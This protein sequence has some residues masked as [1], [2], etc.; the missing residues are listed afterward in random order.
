V[1][2]TAKKK[3]RTQLDREIAAALATKRKSP[4]RRLLTSRTMVVIESDGDHDT[5]TWEDFV[6]ANREMPELE[7]VAEELRSHGRATIGGGAAPLTVVRFA[8]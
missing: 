8:D 5:L 4:Q 7:D 3:T 2:R 1:K 6:D